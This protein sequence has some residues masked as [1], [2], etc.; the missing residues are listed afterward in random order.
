MMTN[1]RIDEAIAL[2]SECN[3]FRITSL[4]LIGVLI[5]ISFIL[6]YAWARDKA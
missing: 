1:V 2:T 4:M 6:A 3:N 5:A